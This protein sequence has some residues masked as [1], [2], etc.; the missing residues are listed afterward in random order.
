MCLRFAVQADG[1]ILVGGNF[2]DAWRR[3][4]GTTARNH[5]GR[6]NADGSLRSASTRARTAIVN[7]LAIQPD[8]NVL[9]AGHVPGP[10]RG[11]TGTTVRRYIGRLLNSDPALQSLT[12]DEG[13]TSVTWLRNGTMPEMR[14]RTL[15]VRLTASPTRRSA[16]SRAGTRLVGGWRITGVTLPVHPNLTVRVRGY[17]ATGLERASGSMT[18]WI[19]PAADFNVIEN[20]DFTLGLSG[21]LFFAT[22]DM[23]YIAHERHRRRS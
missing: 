17:Y 11:G 10:W 8:G 15:P 3:R 21:W 5:L 13:G 19:V 6:L 9:V 18:E 16:P 1:R 2:H 22:P 23:T 12:V 14:P 4:I 7:A 20:G